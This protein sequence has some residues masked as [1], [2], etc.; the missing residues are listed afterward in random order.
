S[1]QPWATSASRLW[2]NSTVGIVHSFW[3]WWGRRA[4]PLVSLVSSAKQRGLLLPAQTMGRAPQRLTLGIG[5]PASLPSIAEAAMP[6]PVLLGPAMG[7]QR[8]VDLPKATQDDF[9]ERVAAVGQTPGAHVMGDRE[10]IQ[11][12]QGGIAV[13]LR[14]VGGIQE[15]RRDPV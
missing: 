12:I 5:T 14:R 1:V 7:Q 10:V 2:R 11:A 4:S 9:E 15:H 8:I 13:F 3:V 6:L